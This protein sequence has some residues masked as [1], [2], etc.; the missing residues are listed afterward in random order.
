MSD[1]GKGSVPRPFSVSHDE[2]S[3]SWDRI[4]GNKMKKKTVKLINPLNKE[5]WMC[6]DYVDTHIVEGVE[7]VKVYKPE[8][9][10]RA[11]L[12]RKDALQKSN[13]TFK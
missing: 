9:P 1:G 13:V 2:Y 8:T 12:M 10:A 3:N 11:H 7:Y 6:D 4:F 5:E